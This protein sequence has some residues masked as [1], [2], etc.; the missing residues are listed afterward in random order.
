LVCAASGLATEPADAPVGWGFV[1]AE[2][3]EGGPQLQGTTWIGQGLGHGIWIKH[4]EDDERV[5][6]LERQIGV[7]IDPWAS[8]P[9]EASR[10]I[11]FLVVLENRSDSRMEFNPIHCWLMTNKE[12]IQTP[13]SLSDMQFDYR[14]NGQ[15]LPKA[16]EKVR[17]VLIGETL[18][19]EA[20]Q[21]VSGLLVYKTVKPK[22]KSFT[23]DTRLTMYNG[24]V[25]KFTAHYRRPPK[26]KKKGKSDS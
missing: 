26:H 22:T 11:T 9:G 21:K 17:P 13:M 7:A 5:A 2:P 16:Y 14:F 10:F 25:V 1:P 20:G 23:V 6:Y 3:V 18:M 12:E 8:P 19:I 4:L 15:D 24:D